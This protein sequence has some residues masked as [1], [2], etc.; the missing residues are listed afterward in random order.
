MQR[1]SVA[2]TDG[3][4]GAAAAARHARRHKPQPGKRNT[5]THSSERVPPR[6]LAGKLCAGTQRDLCVQT[7]DSIAYSNIHALLPAW[8]ARCYDT[9]PA[10]R[11]GNA[12]TCAFL[13][14]GLEKRRAGRGPLAMAF[15]RHPPVVSG[16]FWNSGAALCNR[17]W[18]GFQGGRWAPLLL[19]ESVTNHLDIARCRRVRSR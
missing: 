9:D 14:D 8:H 13:Y 7:G 5:W 4:T 16:R 12:G 6:A 3:R 19:I 10:S 11:A 15:K 17:I 18:S 2:G 1:R